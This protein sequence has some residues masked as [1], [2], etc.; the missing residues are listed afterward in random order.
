MCQIVYWGLQI[1]GSGWA[2]PPG[3]PLDLL[4]VYNQINGRAPGSVTVSSQINGRAQAEV[5]SQVV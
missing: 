2:W 1:W 5:I 4:V 3:P